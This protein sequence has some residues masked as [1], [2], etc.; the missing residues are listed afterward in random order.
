[1]NY[2]LYCTECLRYIDASFDYVQQ[3]SFW[4]RFMKLIYAWTIWYILE[5]VLIYQ[6]LRKRTN[7]TGKESIACVVFLKPQI[8]KKYSLE[9]FCSAH[10]QGKM[11]SQESIFCTFVKM[12]TILRSTP[13]WNLVYKFPMCNDDVCLLIFFVLILFSRRSSDIREERG[14]RFPV[15]AL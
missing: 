8:V 15:V 10:S 14:N 12:L 5:Y 6:H 11:G 7:R 13:Y 2:T 1:M 4:N 9:L 3:L